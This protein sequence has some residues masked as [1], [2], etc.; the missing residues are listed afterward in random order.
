[1][2]NGSGKVSSKVSE[3]SD[4]RLNTILAECELQKPD[5]TMRPSAL[6][7]EGIF[8]D[9]F[10][11]LVEVSLAECMVSSGKASDAVGSSL[12]KSSEYLGLILKALEELFPGMCIPPETIAKVK[13]FSNF[14]SNKKQTY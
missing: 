4:D 2:G 1:M 7:F 8:Y 9:R 5:E 3:I 13:R 10:P 6:N 11:D 14:I 12:L